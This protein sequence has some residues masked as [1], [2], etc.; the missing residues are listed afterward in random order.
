M[1]NGQ[2]PARLIPLADNETHEPLDLVWDAQAQLDRLA[3]SLASQ[4]RPALL[5]RVPSESPTIALDTS[6]ADPQ[7]KFNAGHRSDFRRAERHAARLG[8]LSFE[9]HTQ[10]SEQEFDR[11]LDE[12]FEVEAHNWKG[13][14]GTALLQ[15]QALGSFFR[16]DAQGARREGILRLAFMRVGGQAVGMQ[17]PS[18]SNKAGGCPKSV[19]TAVLPVARRAPC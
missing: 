8:A 11:L 2:H 1:P 4:M 14:A 10:P 6:W 12:A 15:D 16:H 13:D 5:P 7:M 19:M 17:R 18:N 9:I 3:R